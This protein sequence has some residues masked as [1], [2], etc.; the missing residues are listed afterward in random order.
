MQCPQCGSSNTQKSSAMH[1]Q[2]VRVTEGHSTGLFVTSR[3]TFGFGSSRRRSRSSTLSA[4][5]NAPDRTVPARALLV[6]GVGLL[7]SFVALNSGVGLVVFLILVVGTFW[8]V[9]YFSA[10]TDDELAEEKRW[11]SQWYCKKCGEIF[12]DKGTGPQSIVGTGFVSPVLRS[13]SANPRE[14]Y[15]DRVLNPVQ[16]AARATQRDLAGLAA[17][18]ECARPDGTFDPDRMN[19]DLGIV[20]RLSSLGLIR[21]DKATDKF[22]LRTTKSHPAPRPTWWQRTFGA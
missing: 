22:I 16:R 18:E 14:L 10:P 7:L 5:R 13:T 21:Y 20:S 19:C 1:E 15:V 6:G 8:A 11:Q 3:G 12:F 9:I 2:N 4:E 17:I